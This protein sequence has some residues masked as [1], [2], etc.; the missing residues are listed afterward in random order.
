MKWF[1][2]VCMCALLALGLVSTQWVFAQD[3]PPTAPVMKTDRLMKVFSDPIMETLKGAIKEAPTTPKGWRVIQDQGEA[4]AEVAILTM[5][6]EG[7]HENTPEWD[8][9]ADAMKKAGLALADAAAKKD[10]AD[11]QTKTT[12]LIKTCN[13]CHQ[14]FE[15]DTAPEILP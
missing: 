5:L 1:A 4:T 15:P 12:A 9:M 7:E 2:F 11:V 3:A 10:F 8:P 14:K 6:R 13:D